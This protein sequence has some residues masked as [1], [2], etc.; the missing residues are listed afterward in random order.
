M[1]GHAIA[2]GSVLKCE[3]DLKCGLKCVGRG[4]LAGQLAVSAHMHGVLVAG[5]RQALVSPMPTFMMQCY[6]AAGATSRF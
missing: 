5:L 4:K 6:F 3:R 1:Q 2:V